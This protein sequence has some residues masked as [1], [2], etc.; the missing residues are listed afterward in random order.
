MKKIVESNSVEETVSQDIGN[1]IRLPEKFSVINKMILR[2][3]NK[4]VSSPKFYLYTK[5]QISTYLK[6]PNK[7]EKYLRQ[8]VIY[9]YG[10]SSHFRRLVQYFVSL[11][12]LRMLCLR[13]K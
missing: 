9:L 4:N 7:N 8:A 2:D 11:S 10:A 12:D 6:D 1:T 13:I 3:L 5:D